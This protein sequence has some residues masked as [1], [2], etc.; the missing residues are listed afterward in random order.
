ML[1]GSSLE[2]SC[3]LD[4]MLDRNFVRSCKD[5]TPTIRRSALKYLPALCETRPRNVII[6]DVANEILIQALQDNE[7]SDRLFLPT[8][9]SVFFSRQRDTERATLIIPI[10]RSIVRD[11]SWRIRSSLANT[12]PTIAKPFLVD[13][14][15][16][17][18]YPLPLRFLR[19]PEA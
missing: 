8:S 2:M 4:F 6:D 17:G 12:L 11:D 14:V 15:M 10:I 18:V 3:G 1:L 5:Q 16:N 13:S 7:D 19:D 9:L